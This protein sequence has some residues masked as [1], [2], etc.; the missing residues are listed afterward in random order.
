MQPC[1]LEV[2]HWGFRRTCS[3]RIQSQKAVEMEEQSPAE[4]WYLS[5]R[6]HRVI[7]RRTI[8][9][10]VTTV[11]TSNV[12]YSLQFCGHLAQQLR[13]FAWCISSLCALTGYIRLLYTETNHTAAV[14]WSLGLFTFRCIMNE[15]L[16]WVSSW[17][18]WYF[19]IHT[20]NFMTILTDSFKII[21]SKFKPL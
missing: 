14:R 6:L 2:G 19:F 12:T 1:S 20:W 3:L 21:K 17:L 16:L 18:A 7:S 4:C 10:F 5:T 9:F 15:V 11:R 8:I 13:H